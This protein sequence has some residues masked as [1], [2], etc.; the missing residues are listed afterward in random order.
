[1]L[2]GF[3]MIQTKL[4]ILQPLQFQ[5]DKFLGFLQTLFIIQILLKKINKNFRIFFAKIRK[6]DFDSNHIF[7]MNPIVILKVLQNRN[8]KRLISKF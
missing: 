7:R 3:K 6:Y 4:K 2:S 1:M 5:I 8:N